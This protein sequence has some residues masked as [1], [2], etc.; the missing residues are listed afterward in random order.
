ML[1]LM[2]QFPVLLQSNSVRR[3]LF[4][5]KI[6]SSFL[7]GGDGEKDLKDEESQI[8]QTTLEKEQD[9]ARL[10]KFLEKASEVRISDQTNNT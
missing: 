2:L 4:S 3:H 6:K 5:L 7:L 1:T 8:K 9:T 10:N